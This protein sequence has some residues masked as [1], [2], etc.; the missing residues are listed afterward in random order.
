MKTVTSDTS[1]RRKPKLPKRP[2]RW[3]E[4][5]TRKP[6][7]VGSALFVSAIV[8][9]HTANG[10]DVPPGVSGLLESLIY[11]CV[12]GYAASSACEATLRRRAEYGEGKEEDI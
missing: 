1:P 12:G 9:W 4:L 11:A 10:T 8:L 7:A 5:P 3:A 2:F 6:L